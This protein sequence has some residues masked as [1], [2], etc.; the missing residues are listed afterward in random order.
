ML[1]T[2]GVFVGGAASAIV[3]VAVG[4]YLTAFTVAP[5]LRIYVHLLVAMLVGTLTGLLVGW[6]QE[7]HAGVV[8]LACVLPAFVLEIW[9]PVHLGWGR[10]GFALFVLGQISEL[11]IAFCVARYVSNNRN[12]A[13]V[14][15]SC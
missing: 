3:L 15:V 6:W 13:R 14:P 5:A 11:V 2:V 8:A 9:R 1:R 4:V 7:R 12:R 10:P